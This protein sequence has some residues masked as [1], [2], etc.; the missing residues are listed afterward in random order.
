[1]Y[2]AFLGHY[3]VALIP[4]SLIGLLAQLFQ[5]ATGDLDHVSVPIY[6]VFLAM[7]TTLWLESW[8]RQQVTWAFMWAVMDFEEEEEI[9]PEFVGSE[10]RGTVE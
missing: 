8:K 1:M 4:L 2:F 5:L 3:T 7:W 9:R 10:R 6:C